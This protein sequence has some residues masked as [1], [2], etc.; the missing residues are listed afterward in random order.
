[1]KLSHLVLNMQKRN[2]LI[3]SNKTL[4]LLASK[5]KAYQEHIYLGDTYKHIKPY[6]HFQI[7]DM[8]L[9]F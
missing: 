9:F 3:K 7:Y 2:H 5:K 1:M 4:I 8:H 6:F